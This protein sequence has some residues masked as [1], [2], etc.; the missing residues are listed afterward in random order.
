MVFLLE[1]LILGDSLYVF[2]SCTNSL[3]HLH[4]SISFDIELSFVLHRLLSSWFSHW[5]MSWACDIF[6]SSP[7]LPQPLA[8]SALYTHFNIRELNR[9]Q[10]KT[11]ISSAVLPYFSIQGNRDRQLDTFIHPHL[12]LQ[13]THW[14]LFSLSRLFGC[15]QIRRPF[16][17]VLFRMTCAVCLFCFVIGSY[18]YCIFKFMGLCTTYK[19]ANCGEH[20]IFQSLHFQIIDVCSKVTGGASFR[21]YI[22]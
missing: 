9:R 15:I 11:P 8:I 21:H 4:E 5:R 2:Y 22:N 7:A 10:L 14:H 16:K 1:N 18:T 20:I 17:T 19:I 13:Y 3:K 6:E 12:A